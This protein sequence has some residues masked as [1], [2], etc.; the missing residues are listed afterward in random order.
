MRLSSPNWPAYELPQRPTGIW[1]RKDRHRRPAAERHLP[2]LPGGPE[3]DP[4]TIGRKEWIESALGTGH[5]CGG[6]LIE[7][8]HV[9][10]ALTL[11][12]R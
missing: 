2:D 11:L 12:N 9:Q 6:R 3:A 4:L 5:H 8:L 7:R 10:R 1:W